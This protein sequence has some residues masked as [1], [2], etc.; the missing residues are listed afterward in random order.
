MRH[1]TFLLILCPLAALAQPAESESRT[2]QTLLSEVQQLRLAIERSTLLGARTQLAISQLQLQESKAERLTKELQDVREGRAQAES[3]K[4]RLAEETKT[5]EAALGRADTSP[6]LRKD[7]E[8][9]AGH[10]K[11]E[12]EMMAAQVLRQAA[13]EGELASQ[14]M[15]AQREVQ[16]SRAW[17][18]EMQRSL[19][20]AIQQMLK[21]RQ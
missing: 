6:Q 1:L 2:L 10:L 3:Q 12:S 18:S 8:G 20:A 7:I 9:Q 19:D 5:L 11:I 15:A 4:T 14:A 17:I 13:R 21:P 16:D